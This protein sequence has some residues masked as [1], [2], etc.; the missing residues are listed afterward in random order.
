MSLVDCAEGVTDPG[1]Y[2]WTAETIDDLPI[3]NGFHFGVWVGNFNA[4]NV[5]NSGPTQLFIVN[6]TT[7]TS[8][9]TVPS[10]SA[11]S[12]SSTS[13]ET[14]ISQVTLT[15]QVDDATTTSAVTVP[16]TSAASS[17][18]S[19]MTSTSQISMTSYSYLGPPELDISAYF[20][21]FC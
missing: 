21:L 2:D 11:A 17:S 12:S 3:T 9:V 5:I 4:S 19:Q 10:T 20:A 16:S 14:A 7:T 15:S 18:T 1:S 6:D 8:V 13:H